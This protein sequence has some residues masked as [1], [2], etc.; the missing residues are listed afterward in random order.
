MTRILLVSV[1]QPWPEH[2]GGRLRTARV[3]TALAESCD[4]EVAFPLKDGGVVDAPVPVHPLPWHPAGRLGSRASLRPHLGEHH[5]APVLPSL[6]RLADKRAPDFVYWSHSYLAATG[7]RALPGFRHIVEFANIEGDRLAT[8]A[9]SANGARKAVRLGESWKARRWEPDVAVGADICVA[10]TQSDA[11][12]LSSWGART[13]LVPNGVDTVD[14]TPSPADGYVLALASY[15]YE[16]NLRA[17]EDFVSHSW[18]AV[19]SKVPHARLVIAGRNSEALRKGI[20]LPGVSVIGTL[21]RVDDA[22]A[23]A[24][25]S[26]TPA[27]VGGGA[28]L[29]VTESLGRGRVVVATAYSSRSVPEELRGTQAC[30]M[31]DSP[32]AFAT[33]IGMTLDGVEA[34]HAA[35]YE[36][37]RTL[38]HRS[39]SRLTLPLLEAMSPTPP[40]GSQAVRTES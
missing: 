14:Y 4:V 10:L 20:R 40:R 23:G 13:V 5:L 2:H 33:A 34:R 28:Q 36:A 31:A 18:P 11:D 26:L 8:L 32:D 16:P 22:Y 25:M 9:K 7:M 12:R 6:R 35:E 30:V 15:D 21:D 1:E 24:A 3:A 38:Q 19:L 29:K 17:I 37:R 39:W 27:Q